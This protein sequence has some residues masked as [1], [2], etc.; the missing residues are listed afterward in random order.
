MSSRRG[1]V[2]SAYGP[3]MNTFWG[4]DTDSMT[5]LAALFGDRAGTLEKLAQGAGTT[6][7]TV[8][9][10]GPDADDFT[11]DV[12]EAVETLISLVETIRRLGELLGDEAEDQDRASSPGGGD[13]YGV[14]TRGGAG[15]PLSGILATPPRG[16]LVDGG[17]SRPLEEKEPWW[18]TP[19]GGPGLILDPA[20]TTKAFRKLVDLVDAGTIGPIIGGPMV[21]PWA[22]HRPP[23][24][25]PLP[26]GEGFDLDPELLGRASE[27]RSRVTGALPVVGM[28]ESVMELQQSTEGRAER[29]EQGLVDAGLDELTPLTDVVG[30]A[31]RAMGI[32]LGKDSQPAQVLDGVDRMWANTQ[33]TGGEVLSAVVDGDPAAALRAAE[34][35][36]YRHGDAVADVLT[37]TPIPVATDA[38]AS[39][40]EDLAGHVEH[41]SPEAAETM[42]E[43]A[44]EIRESGERWQQAQDEITDGETRYDRR[45]RHAP[46]PWDPTE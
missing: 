30:S 22:R 25:G 35:G 24:E 2:T 6:A 20:T 13:V 15:G 39:F 27:Q 8:T 23:V 14:S 11:I 33:Q 36:A 1:T 26:E 43:N 46:L 38:G 12:D 45:R 21:S 37:A 42:R 10:F 17:P 3:G 29:W 5:E 34:R 19:A 7:R 28:V 18:R 9:W 32:F 41:V 44:A 4:C 31:D 16:P 40:A